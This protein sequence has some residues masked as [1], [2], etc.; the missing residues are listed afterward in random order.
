MLALT[1]IFVLIENTVMRVLLLWPPTTTV[2]GDHTSVSPVVQRLGLAYL[3]AWLKKKGH[4]VSIIDGRGSRQDK[5]QFETSISYGLSDE[6][7][8]LKV[9]NYHPD[10]IGTSNM[11][12]AYSGDPHRLA[13]LIKD[14]YPLNNILKKLRSD[15]NPYLQ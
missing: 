2:Y 3:A 13:K 8:L 1:S 12:T 7:V 5:T 9:K 6:E 14:T 11:W 4:E 10:I 15:I